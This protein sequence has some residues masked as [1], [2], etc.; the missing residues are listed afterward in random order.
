MTLKLAANLSE[1]EKTEV[2]MY[3]KNKIAKLVSA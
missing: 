2:K 1:K 3:Y